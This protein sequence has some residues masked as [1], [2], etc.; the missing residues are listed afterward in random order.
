[1][2][3]SKLSCPLSPVGAK[4]TLKSTVQVPPLIKN[5][6]LF[7]RNIT[8]LCTKKNSLWYW[9]ALLGKNECPKIRRNFYFN[10]P[11]HLIRHIRQ[12]VRRP[13]VGRNQKSRNVWYNGVDPDQ[14]PKDISFAAFRVSVSLVSLLL[15]KYS[16]DLLF[17]PE[18]KSPCDIAFNV[19]FLSFNQFNA[20]PIEYKGAPVVF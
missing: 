7:P 20:G 8:E 17:L 1:M 15:L 12:T 14:V 18:D 5:L 4:P 3:I 16:C 19:A 9:R 13:L 6:K 11:S 2:Y 10:L